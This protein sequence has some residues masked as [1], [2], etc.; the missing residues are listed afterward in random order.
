VPF[1]PSQLWKNLSSDS[2]LAAAD[3]FWR[4][5][6]ALEQQV[7]AVVMLAKRL[8]FRPKS[9]QALPIERRTKMLAQ[10]SDV[11]ETIATRALIAYHFDKQRAL[12]GAFLDALG[13]TH[14]N[15]LI[16][17]EEISPPDHERLATAVSAIRA[18]F[19]AH[20][21]DLYLQ[22]LIAIDQD[23]WGG[24]ETPTAHVEDTG[25]T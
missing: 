6:Q 12:M 16:T 8:K 21:V 24:I 25:R 23:T 18:S 22:T 10:V 3:A 11:S 5:D 2:R 7:E 4:D 13:I 9:L 20:D 19:P 15:G 1:R 17:A 14:D